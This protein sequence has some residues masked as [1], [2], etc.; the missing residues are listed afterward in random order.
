MDELKFSQ[1]P[2]GRLVRIQ[3]TDVRFGIDYEH[4]AYVP[5]PLGIPPTL[6]EPT[7]R[8][9]VRATKAIA[10]LDQASR[11]VRNPSL[12]R[13]P[14]LR[15]EAQSTSA[16]EGTFAPLEDV[17]AADVDEREHSHELHEVLNYVEAADMAFSA[18]EARPAI[19]K[20]LL[21][22]IHRVLVRGTRAD[23]RDAGRVRGGQ[24]AIGSRSGAIEESRF[25]PMPPGADL[26]SALRDLL[27]WVASPQE[28]EPIVAAAMAHY[29]FETLHP[30][31][32]GNGRIGRLI[33][34]LQLM[35]LGELREPLL[36]VSPWFEARR[37][38]YQQRLADV[39]ATGD[40][41][42]WIRFFAEG[43]ESSATDIS[44]R[45]DRLLAIAAAYVE[46]AQEHRISGLARDIIDELIGTPILTASAVRDRFNRTSQA[47][48]LALKRLVEVGI[49]DGPHGSY[50]RLFVANDVMRTLSAPVGK[51]L[52]PD[53]PLANR[54]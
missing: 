51:V 44:A 37:D 46:K 2:I 9:L 18:I 49:L 4:V 1:S 8:A 47:S 34:V 43:V 38:E 54:N 29:Q 40:W 19:T 3:G 28:C 21:E 31:N 35:V 10:R 42:G 17:L 11:L 6:S 25:V 30:F 50:N 14:T 36:S 27:D 15:R 26:E 22:E 41:D 16:L 13:R 23:N 24:V 52:A 45:V 12:L 33:I 53:A 5:D 7:W 20:G 48:G 39:S 32:D